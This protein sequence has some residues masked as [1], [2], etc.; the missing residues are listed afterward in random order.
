MM[1]AVVT[2]VVGVEMVEKWWLW[3]LGLNEEEEGGGG[4]GFV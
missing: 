4:D 3:V 2:V 1:K